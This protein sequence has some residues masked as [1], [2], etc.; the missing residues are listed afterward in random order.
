MPFLMAALAAYHAG[1]RQVVV[2]GAPGDPATQALHQEVD[3]RYLPFTVVLPVDA[4]R[5]RASIARLLPFVSA[6]TALDGRPTAF[7]CEGFS[8]QAP[9]TDPEMLGRQLDDLRPAA[10][11]S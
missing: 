11:Q 6:L 9:T 4:E 10:R 7:V 2:L 3:R 5:T 1:V 8:C